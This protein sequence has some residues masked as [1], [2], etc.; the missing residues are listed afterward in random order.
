MK[1]GTLINIAF[2]KARDGGSQCLLA[3]LLRLVEPTRGEPGCLQYEICKSPTD[4][5][6]VVVFERW[7]MPS[8]FYAHMRTPYVSAFMSKVTDLCSQDVEIRTFHLVTEPD[9]T[10]T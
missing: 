6:D 10:K 8:D 7:N 2:F 5:H 4:P 9:Q 3:E 1:A